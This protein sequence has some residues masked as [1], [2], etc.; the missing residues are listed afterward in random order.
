MCPQDAALDYGLSCL[1]MCPQDAAE[2]KKAA[3]AVADKVKA[4]KTSVSLG[5]KKPAGPA[6]G[7]APAAGAKKPASSA[8]G[9]S[10]AKKPAETKKPAGSTDC[11]QNLM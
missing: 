4:E 3:K 1:C 2:K 7:A 6:A 5:I 11:T 8:S 10:E 9:P